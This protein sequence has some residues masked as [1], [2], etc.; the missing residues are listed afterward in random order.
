MNCYFLHNKLTFL[1][2]LFI[3]HHLKQKLTSS[4]PLNH[5]KNLLNVVQGSPVEMK[6]EV[7]SFH[8]DIRWIEWTRNSSHSPVLVKFVNYQAYVD[9]EFSNRLSVNRY[10]DLLINPARI[11]DSDIYT[12]T[13]YT[14]KNHVATFIHGT[15]V[16]LKIQ[17]KC[18]S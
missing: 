12:C 11:K 6:C 4:Q 16:R 13:T 5:S 15:S 10:G 3:D 7:T 1:H 2:K 8:Q 9:P 18:D 17:G 14:L